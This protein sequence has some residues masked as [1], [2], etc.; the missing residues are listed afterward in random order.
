MC[1]SG[2]H[3]VYELLEDKVVWHILERDRT[4]LPKDSYPVIAEGWLFQGIARFGYYGWK[5]E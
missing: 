3:N 2:G 1:R 5:D 4:D